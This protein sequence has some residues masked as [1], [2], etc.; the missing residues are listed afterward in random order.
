MGCPAS[1]GVTVCATVSPERTTKGDVPICYCVVCVTR[2]TALIAH[3]GFVYVL[4]VVR[5]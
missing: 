1:E 4:V 3:D 2:V 5:I